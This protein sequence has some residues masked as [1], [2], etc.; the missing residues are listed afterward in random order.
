VSFL[1]TSVIRKEKADTSVIFIY[2]SD[3]LPDNTSLKGWMNGSKFVVQAV[4]TE[5]ST[6]EVAEQLAWLGAALRTS[7]YEDGI[8]VCTPYVSDASIV[9]CSENDALGHGLAF[10]IQPTIAAHFKLSFSFHRLITDAK[11]STGQCWQSLFLNPVL[12]RGYPIAR[13]MEG[14]KGL[15]LSLDVMATLLQARR[16]TWFGAT[17]FIKGFSAMVIPT[18]VEEGIL[19]WHLVFNEDQKQRISYNDSRVRRIIDPNAEQINI[20]NLETA[21]HILGWCPQVKSLTG[22]ILL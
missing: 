11:D 12:V 10:P 16:I 6:M 2:F 14:V 9:A 8:A 18:K 13:R 17:P 5:S 21:Q 19:L 4:G 1:I 7:P 15:E 20:V 22:K 3:R